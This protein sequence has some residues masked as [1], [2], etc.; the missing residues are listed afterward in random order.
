M[1]LV[2]TGTLVF[3]TFRL[4]PTALRFDFRRDL[5]RLATLKSFPI[6]PAA[7]TI[8]QTLAPV[9]ITTLFQCGV[10]T[11]AIIARSLPPHHLILVLLVI[12]PLNVTTRLQTAI[13]ARPR[14]HPV[15]D[16]R[17][18]QARRFVDE[19][20]LLDVERPRVTSNDNRYRYEATSRPL[21]SVLNS[22]RT[23]RPSAGQKDAEYDDSAVH[24]FH[25]INSYRHCQLR[26]FEGW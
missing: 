24:H 25:R 19:H 2:A 1:A 15:V 18:R 5:D 13:A 22:I 12:I 8:G 21:D 10:L 4:L 3:Y 7:E 16:D 9:L 17:D 23:A 11:S 26:A 20:S 14:D 6:T